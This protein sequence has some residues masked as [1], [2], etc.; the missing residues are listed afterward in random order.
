MEYSLTVEPVEETLG[1]RSDQ[2]LLDAC[3][4]AGVWLPHAC[5]HGLCGTCKVE[6]LD[7]EV[8]HGEASPFALMDFER[9]EGYTL[10]CSARP[11]SD[12]TI[13]A[14]IDVD[15]DAVIRPVQDFAGRVA[16]IDR[17]TPD[18]AVIT[19]ETEVPVEFQAGQY[20]NLT[21]DGVDAPRAF[22]FA[23][24]PSATNAVELHVRLVPDGAATT[25]IHR[26]LAVGDE[27]RFAGPYGR[28]FVRRSVGKPLLFLA[29]GSGL[30]S[31]K[32]MVLD[33]LETGYEESI[34]LIHGV[35]TSA[36]VYFDELFRELEAT[37]EQFRYVPVL[38]QPGPDDAGW[39][40]ETGFVHEVA[41]RLYDGKFKGNQAYLCGP[42]P[43]IEAC[44]RTLMKG[45]LFERDIFTERFVTAADGEAGLAKSPLFKRV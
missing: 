1:V 8:D 6:V 2:T 23:N 10:A 33:L 24:S 41:E 12:V 34:T 31:P 38:S 15:P 30:S 26:D 11:R 3:L 9:E 16:R 14:D 29:G 44:I 35:R 36:D 32:S 43:M 5:G 4:R 39:V 37:H 17:P 40:G 25:R 20:L 42:P 7:G 22:S 27:L 21:V 13:E 19:I 45:R 28:F 18:I